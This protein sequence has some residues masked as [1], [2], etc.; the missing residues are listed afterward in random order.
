MA[1]IPKVTRNPEKEKIALEKGTLTWEK[2]S[3]MD[4]TFSSEIRHESEAR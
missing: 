4:S 1:T 2:D 3:Q